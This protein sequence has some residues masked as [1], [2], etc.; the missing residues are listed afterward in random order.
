MPSVK[1]D[2]IILFV[3]KNSAP[4]AAVDSLGSPSSKHSSQMFT[5]TLSVT[6]V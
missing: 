1:R 2:Q 6:D 5:R 4:E 3:G